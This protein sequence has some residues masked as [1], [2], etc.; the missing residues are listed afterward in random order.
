MVPTLPGASDQVTGVLAVRWIVPPAETAGGFDGVIFTAAGE[1]AAKESST[2]R[3]PSN[4]LLQSV[5][6]S[7]SNG[8]CSLDSSVSPDGSSQP[9]SRPPKLVAAREHSSQSRFQES[10]G[11]RTH[12]QRQRFFRRS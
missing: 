10:L 8:N 2:K 9:Q 6:S 1:S 12:S 11:R 3:G 5:G 7:F 4:Q